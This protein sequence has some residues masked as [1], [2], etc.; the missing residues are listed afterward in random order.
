M[1]PDGIVKACTPHW[2]ITSAS[3]TAMKMASAY[4]RT[5]DLRRA[6]AWASM[7][8]GASGRGSVSFRLRVCLVV[9]QVM[10]GGRSEHFR[11]RTCHAA[12]GFC[13]LPRCA[14]D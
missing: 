7:G 13:L 3:N 2:R 8:A 14:G 4:S 11:P 12:C 1:E 10:L 6:G 9:A 5:S